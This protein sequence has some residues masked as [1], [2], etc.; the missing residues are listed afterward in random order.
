MKSK[1][2]MS[3]ILSKILKKSLQNSYRRYFSHTSVYSN[4]KNYLEEINKLILSLGEYREKII[5]NSY[6]ETQFKWKVAKQM[7]KEHVNYVDKLDTLG[8]IPIALKYMENDG[9]V[10]F[11][12]EICEDS[13]VETENEVKIPYGR[14]SKLL[15][16]VHAE[17]RF[18]IKEDTCNVEEEV[19]MR[20][21]MQNNDSNWML[22][23]EKYND[24]DMANVNF[25]GTEDPRSPISCIPCGGCGAYLHCR[26]SS[27]PG[28]IPSE[29][30][31][32]YNLAKSMELKS[33]ICQR[34]HFLKNYNLALQLRVS[35]DD[36]P[37]VLSTI[38]N[39]KQALVVL[40]VDLLDFPCS[41]WPGITDLIGYNRPILIVG[42][43]VDLLQVDDKN[44]LKRI[45]NRLL[46][47]MKE[48]GFATTNIKGVSL[49]SAK[50][51]FGV[52][53]LIN[54]L[55]AIWKYNGK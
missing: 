20:Y 2:K 16:K 12:E 37:K 49:I 50:T 5:Y 11:E 13:H 33:L 27:L 48:C 29:I 3:V 24:E 35:S 38:K 26:D 7:K 21:N 15:T 47:S 14:E 40:M 4:K 44:F 41:I 19:K 9:S 23:Y 6:I 1:I 18:N 46:M 32:N 10:S 52:E 45:E 54:N 22:D 36:Y 39:Y 53:N 55:H 17:E 42:N 8:K 31:K 30:Y 34:C 25:Y 51:G 28:Y 43:K